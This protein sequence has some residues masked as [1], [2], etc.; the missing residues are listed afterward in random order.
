MT[1]A[2][3]YAIAR[4]AQNSSLWL[5]SHGFSLS[6]TSGDFE[7]WQGTTDLLEVEPL[8]QHEIS[9]LLDRYYLLIPRGDV[10]ARVGVTESFVEFVAPTYEAC[11]AIEQ[12]LANIS[13]LL[14]TFRRWMELTPARRILDFGCGTGLSARVSPAVEL[15]GFDSSHAMRAH[16]RTAGMRVIDPDGLRALP[17]GHFD[18]AFASYVMHLQIGKEFVLEAARRI[19]SNGLWIANF[20]KGIGFDWAAGLLAGEGFALASHSTSPSHG[21]I[22]VFMRNTVE[23]P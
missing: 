12:N 15:I 10:S 8:S 22:A 16:A 9:R 19:R 11:V 13:G 14:S 2:P 5:A 6:E 23:A 4:R 20:H 3:K 7:L 17:V 1:Q 18:G 21:D